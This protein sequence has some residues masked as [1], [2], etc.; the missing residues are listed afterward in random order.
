MFVNISYDLNFVTC[1]PEAARLGGGERGQLLLKPLLCSPM[2]SAGV[3]LV[4]EGRVSMVLVSVGMLLVCSN[5]GMG[6][7]I[8]KLI[9]YV[10][11][12]HP[13]I[14]TYQ[15]VAYHQIPIHTLLKSDTRMH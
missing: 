9:P 4:S 15:Y 8:L 11:I 10:P 14:R 5:V 3:D 6:I 13:H 12:V 7:S 1:V 2:A